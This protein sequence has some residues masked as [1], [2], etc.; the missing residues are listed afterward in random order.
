MKSTLTVK[1][2]LTPSLIKI[3]KEL[4]TVPDQAYKYWESQ[5]P[6]RSGNARRSTSL[7]GQTIKAKY[8]YAAKL[9]EGY[10]KQ[11]PK[12]MSDPTSK[13]VTALIK[14]IMRK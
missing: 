11:A 14:R 12:G 3:K 6:V 5:T 10:S 2:N 8:P 9:N 4:A 1:N 13:F 7:Q